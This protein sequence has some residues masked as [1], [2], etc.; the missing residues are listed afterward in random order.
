M[1][2]KDN[3]KVAVKWIDRTLALNLENGFACETTRAL[4]H[5]L[6]EKGQALKALEKAIT[7]AK[8]QAVE[9]EYQRAMELYDE[10]KRK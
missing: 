2:E 5:K 4:Q 1:E 10:L 9:D 7:L 3:L 8:A 6:G